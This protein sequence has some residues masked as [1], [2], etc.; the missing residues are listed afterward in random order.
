MERKARR[1]GIQVQ[2]AASI[3]CACPMLSA[4]PNA[5][6]MVRNCSGR[7]DPAFSTITCTFKSGRAT[8][9][10][11]AKAGETKK[12]KERSPHKPTLPP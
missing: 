9:S 6:I 2:A 4:R 11:Q 12:W 1:R 10:A 5:C 7:T 8:L 3:T